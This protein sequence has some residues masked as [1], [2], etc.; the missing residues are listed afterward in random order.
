MR[1]SLPSYEQLLARAKNSAGLITLT[2]A[3]VISQSIVSGRKPLIR[4]LGEVRFQQMMETYFDGLMLANGDA[5]GEDARGDE[6]DDLLQLLLEYRAEQTDERAWLSYA[7]ATASMGNNHLWQ[8][9][10]LPSRKALSALIAEHFPRLFAR[11][12]GD[13]KWKKFFYRLLCERA[14]IPICKS[15]S[16]AVCTDFKHCFG[17]EEDSDTVPP[18]Q[19]VS[20]RVTS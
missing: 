8:D 20:M 12:D 14:N 15:P 10:G 6:F 3:G 5:L 16:C 17:S 1:Q 11:N 2:F 13:M 4:A 19:V 7:I 9:M 18:I